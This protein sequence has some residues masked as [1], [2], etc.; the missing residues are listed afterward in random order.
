M[1]RHQTRRDKLRRA[2]KKTGAEALLVTDFTNVTYLTGFTGEDS[3]LLV[4]ADGEVL[5]SDS[6]FTT[7]LDEECPGLNV[8]IRTQ[9]VKMLQVIEKMLRSCK[10]S[11]LGIEAES[12]TV[13]LRDQIAGEM[14]KL[15]IIPTAGL[16]EDLRKIKDRD[17]IERL[18]RAVRIAAKAFGVLRATLRPDKTEIEVTNELEHQMRLF[19]A[20]CRGFQSIVGVG[21]GSFAPRGPHRASGRPERLH[22]GRLGRQ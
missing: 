6:R 3:Y 16:V 2:I 4:R 13:A 21:P 18:R 15:K 10:I 17:E 22:F 20:K 7:Q 14:P 11:R 12:M 9:K 1:D 19:G 8:D 5:L